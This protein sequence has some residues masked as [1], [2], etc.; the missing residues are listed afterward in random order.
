MEQYI[1][2]Q[3]ILNIHKRLFG[4]E[5]L[6]RGAKNYKLAD[7]S[8]DRATSAL[9]SSA[10]LTRD[11]KE[12]SNHRP[13]FINFTQNLIEQNVPA[14][15]PKSQIVVELLE[16]IE[17]NKKVISVCRNLSNEGYKIALDDFVFHRKFIPLLDF[18]D[19]IKIDVRLTPLDTIVRTL[20]L[21]S[22]YK[23]KLLAEKVETN[24][25]FEK[26]SKLGFSYFQG[27]FFSKPEQIKITELSSSKVNM[28]RL[29]NEVS[30]KKTTLNR[31]HEIISNDI[32]TSYKLLRFLNS[33]Y[34]YRLQEVKSVKHAIAYLG[35]KELRRFILLIIVSEL[36]TKSPGELV[37]LVLVRA[38]LCELLGL[39]S[40][41]AD[42]SEELFILGLFSALDTMLNGPMKNILNELPVDQSI[43]EALISKTGI[44]ASFLTAATAF[45]RNQPEVI[46]KHI[47]ILNIDQ[48]KISECYLTAVKYANGLM[49]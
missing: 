34:F 28:L 22:H 5:L 40:P 14:S 2:R 9:L 43:K 24:D 30:Q 46:K 45:E 26:A 17:P 1:A 33:A 23:V 35:E 38:K 37:R 4:Y 29:L 27:Y 25:E 20:N 19:I 49:R 18:V 6:Y 16:D 42:K 3:P 48:N 32:A 36:S 8:G 41:H 21:L 11:I 44:L 47:K 39:S 13:C 7:V 12:I 10:F 15:F 31:L